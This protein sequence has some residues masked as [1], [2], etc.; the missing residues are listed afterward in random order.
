MTCPQAKC[1]KSLAIWLRLWFVIRIA[2]RKSLAIWNTVN[3][4]R[5]AHCSDYLCR[6]TA[7]MPHWW[8]LAGIIKKTELFEFLNWSTLNS[9]EQ[10]IHKPLLTAWAKW[11]KASPSIRSRSGKPDQKE[12]DSQ[13]GSRYRGAFVNSQ[14]FPWKKQGEFT[15]KTIRGNH[16]FFCE[17]SR[18][19][20]DQHSEFRRKSTPFFRK[21]VRKSALFFLW[22]PKS[23]MRSL[24]RLAK[25]CFYPRVLLA[26][27]ST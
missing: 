3:L 13:A 18:F 25:G 11:S 12:F 7:T 4:L 16:R 21:P 23:R 6:K 22:T 2:N 1:S 10:G 19:S 9:E 26:L 24:P 14:C 15:K 27:F 17:F 8:L 20:Q 5:K